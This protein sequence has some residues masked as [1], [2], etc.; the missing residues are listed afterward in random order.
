MD[1]SARWSAPLAGAIVLTLHVCLSSCFVDRSGAARAEACTRDEECLRGDICVLGECRRL[2]DASTDANRLDAAQ[3]PQDVGLDTGSVA[4]PVNHSPPVISG[5]AEVGATLT[6]RPGERSG[7]PAPAL[8]YQWLRNGMAIAGATLPTYRISGEDAAPAASSITVEE[9]ATNIAGA[10]SAESNG[11][12]VAYDPSFETGLILD[13]WAE[14]NLTV[15]GSGVARWEDRVARH[16]FSQGRDGLRPSVSELGPRPAIYFQ[17][18]AEN[19]V[20]TTSTLASVADT[21]SIIA[22]V[23]L[24]SVS[25]RE[26]L[27]YSEQDNWLLALGTRTGGQLGVFENGTYHDLGGQVSGPQILTWNLSPTTAQLW[28]GESSLGSSDFP[29]VGLGG[30]IGLGGSYINANQ[31]DC[32]IGRLMVFDT[33]DQTRD[34]RVR[35]YL[36]AYYGI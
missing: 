3:P 26:F 10:V 32:K 11:L 20:H 13:L 2:A 21:Y 14:H 22:A 31:C 29:G 6:V 36:R 15:V 24:E 5:D 4:T 27:V 19:L 34:V 8:S 35:A 16:D 18:N 9:T 17:A 25:T 7:R 12:T 23:S 1:R 28:R 33:L 30:R